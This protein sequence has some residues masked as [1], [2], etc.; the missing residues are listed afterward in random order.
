[1]KTAVSGVACTLAV[2]DE[3]G[4]A[5]EPALILGYDALRSARVVVDSAR[6]T[7]WFDWTV[8]RQR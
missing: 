4:L 3:F 5:D 7:V 1:M 6:D 2:F 8:A